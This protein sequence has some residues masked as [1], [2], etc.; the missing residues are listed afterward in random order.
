MLKLWKR[1]ALLKRGTWNLV[2][3]PVGKSAIGCR[4]VYKIKTH[5]YG[6]VDH[7]KARLVDK[8][9]PKKYGIN[10]DDTFALVA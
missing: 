7:Y 4:W 8:R 5:F 2:G 1:D 6:L 10:Y 3:L 9:F